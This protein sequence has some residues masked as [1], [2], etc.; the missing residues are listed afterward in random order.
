MK[1]PYVI[2][3]VLLVI[4]AIFAALYF[5]GVFDDGVKVNIGDAAPAEIVAAL[6]L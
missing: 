4:G 3:V 6:R 1:G 5:A 2:V